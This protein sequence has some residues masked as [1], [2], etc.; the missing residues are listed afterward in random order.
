MVF[1]VGIHID[2]EEGGHKDIRMTRQ[3]CVV[4][5]ST[6]VEQFP[7]DVRRLLPLTEDPSLSINNDN[8]GYK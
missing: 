7:D 2:K 6:C 4:N 1:H 5:A 3:T 8:K